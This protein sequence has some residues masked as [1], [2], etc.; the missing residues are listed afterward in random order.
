MYSC[1]DFFN[2][3]SLQYVWVYSRKR[4]LTQEMFANVFTALNKTKI[5]AFPLVTSDQAFC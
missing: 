5:D 4:N 1:A 2:F 3:S